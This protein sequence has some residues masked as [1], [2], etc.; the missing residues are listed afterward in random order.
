[1]TSLVLYHTSFPPTKAMADVSASATCME[2]VDRA[3]MDTW[4][5]VTIGGC[6][7]SNNTIQS[8]HFFF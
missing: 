2:G 3:A 4:F 5:V 8:L 1:M 7:L 6:N